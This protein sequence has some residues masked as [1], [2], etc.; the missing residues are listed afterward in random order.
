VFVANGIS[1]VGSPVTCGQFNNAF[2]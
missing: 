1:F 2:Q